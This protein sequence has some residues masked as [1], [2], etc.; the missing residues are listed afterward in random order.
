MNWW[1]SWLLH[2]MRRMN[3]LL[4]YPKK[5]NENSILESERSAKL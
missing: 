1:S 4:Q 5:R 2:Q 3:M